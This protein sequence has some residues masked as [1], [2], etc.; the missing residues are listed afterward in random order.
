V[1]GVAAADQ[2]AALGSM[3]T[4][5]V[6]VRD[7]LSAMRGRLGLV[8]L[9]LAIAGLGWWWTARSMSGMD[10]GPGTDLGTLGWFSGAWV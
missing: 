3:P 6:G 5:E 7:A 8:A 1:G 10:A 9:L 2:A 4:A